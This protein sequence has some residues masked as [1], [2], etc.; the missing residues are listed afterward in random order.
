MAPGTGKT[1]TSAHIL[2]ELMVQNSES[3]ALF[4][5]H[6]NDILK[7]ADKAFGE[8][9]VPGTRGFYHGNEKA[10]RPHE[11]RCL[12]ASF[13]TMEGHRESFDPQEFD[14]VVV[15]ESHHAP[16]A[17]YGPTIE[18][19][20]PKFS[21]GMTATPDRVD[22]QDV[23]R[24][25]GRELYY[26]PLERAIARGILAK[27]DYRLL[28]DE[29]LDAGMLDIPAGRLSVTELNRRLFIPRRDEEIARL[30][31]EKIESVQNP[32]LIIFCPS[33]PYCNRLAP[34]FPGSLALHS[35]LSKTEQNKR[36][37][38]FREGEFSTILTVDKFNEGIDL[39]DA[40]VI[41]FLRSTSSN[42][43]FEQQLGRGL[44]K[45]EGEKE[46]V[47]VLDFVANCERIERIYTLFKDVESI[48]RELRGIDHG[49]TD[50]G[51][52][53]GR[54]DELPVLIDVGDVVFTEVARNVVEL[55]RRI[56]SANLAVTHREL[57]AEY[58]P[59]PKNKLPVGQVIA[60][61]NEKL[62]WKCSV[63]TCGYEWEA[64]GNNRVK[65][66][67]CPACSG[68]VA[69]PTNNLALVRPDLAKEYMTS[70]NALPPD[71]IT[72]LS[73][74]VVWWK[75][76]VRKC[77]FEWRTT[78]SHRSVGNTGCPAC[79]HNVLTPR[80]S[81]ASIRPDLAKEYLVPPENDLPANKMFPGTDKKVWWRC[82]ECGD[83]YEARVDH[84]SAGSGCPACRGR[85]LV[86]TATN[87]LAAV[88]PALAA[89]YMDKNRL[90]ADTIHFGAKEV[91]WW[92]CPDC[93]HEWEVSPAARID[94]IK[95]R[96][97]PSGCRPCSYRNGGRRRKETAV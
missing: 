62:W 80:H 40:N 85:G 73:N 1:V 83:K 88:H 17:T 92:K 45:I 4:L 52:E 95:S 30:T 6:Q 57:A 81:L 70:K 38:D 75:C 29:I 84:R 71:Q 23:R 96:G 94:K 26:L 34:L 86:I 63:T 19:F 7:Q 48:Q 67:G 65:G 90:P 77:R 41:V 93:G 5:C 66:K 74:R 32:R 97:K 49:N 22:M 89:Q 76:S 31:L 18:Y 50:E 60:G 13:Q 9:E 61:T 24:F 15:D 47:L 3:R 79:S 91:V 16:A 44:R 11:V 51:G 56:R 78:P 33:I 2:R 69:T 58:M 28:T 42:V 37:Q 36:L 55:L 14:Y 46:S 8:E 82:P 35:G 54:G 59:P 43:V 20:K 39:P 10:R 12:F 64:T 87:N 25:F 27:V 68:R 21:I 53:Q 72:P